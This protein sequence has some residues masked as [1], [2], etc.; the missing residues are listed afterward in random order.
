MTAPL[1]P[2]GRRPLGA[3]VGGYGAVWLYNKVKDSAPDSIR[4]FMAAGR[5]DIARSIGEAVA[6]LREAAHQHLEAA[7][8]QETAE[9]GSAEAAPV[10]RPGGWDP[11]ATPV[12]LLRDSM[13]GVDVRAAS[14][15]L[16]VSERRVRQ[17]L[18]SGELRGTRDR[19]GRWVIDPADLDRLTTDRR[20]AA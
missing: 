3:H 1:I 12:P 15:V 6:D 19:A 11:P 10:P 18:G 7:D 9:P 5:P 8:D 13:G 4:H 17:L 20:L 14:L 2:R 16:S